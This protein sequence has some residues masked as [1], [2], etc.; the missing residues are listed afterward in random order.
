MF[1]PR[2]TVKVKGV[3]YCKRRA[4]KGILSGTSSMAGPSEDCIPAFGVVWSKLVQSRLSNNE[5][6]RNTISH[7]SMAGS[8][9]T[10]RRTVLNCQ[11]CKCP[12][13]S[14]YIMYVMLMADLR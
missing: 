1:G 2:C 5:G 14:Q 4:I 12:I 3:Q 11:Q 6:A 13:A 8:A 7:R 9:G 10:C